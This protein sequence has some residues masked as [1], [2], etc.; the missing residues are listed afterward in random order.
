MRSEIGNDIFKSV[1]ILNR[2]GIVA[3]PTER[4]SETTGTSFLRKRMHRN[5][6]AIFNNF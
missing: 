4:Q 1:E 2:G 6:D 5:Y 3:I